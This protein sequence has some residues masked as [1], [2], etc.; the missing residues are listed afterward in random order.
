MEG[1]GSVQIITDP[2]PRVPKT[3]G[4]GSRTLAKIMTGDLIFYYMYSSADPDSNPYSLRLHQ[5]SKTHRYS[6][7]DTVSML[8]NRLG[9]AG[10]GTITFANINTSYLK[11][12]Y[13]IYI[14]FVW[15]WYRRPKIN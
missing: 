14:T 3:Y 5:N 12:D 8:N 15:K 13:S 6:D 2:D 10:K 11:A 9:N 1:S 7:S 4:S